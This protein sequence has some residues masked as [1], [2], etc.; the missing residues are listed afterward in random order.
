MN[1]SLIPPLLVAGS[2]I[3]AVFF[4]LGLKPIPQP[5]PKVLHVPLVGQVMSQWCWAAT[6]E[7]VTA[8]YHKLDPGNPLVTQCDLVKRINPSIEIDC[9]DLSENDSMANEPGYPFANVKAYSFSDWL[10][11]GTIPYDTLAA[12]FA[13]G[14]PV[15]FQWSN[16]GL[17]PGKKSD[18][19]LMSGT[20]YPI[21]A[22]FL[23]ADGLPRSDYSD[24]LWVSVNDP[25]PL[26]E[27]SHKVMAYSAFA[28]C[29]PSS[30]Q[31]DKSAYLLTTIFYGNSGAIYKIQ[32]T[33][34]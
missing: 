2:S 3:A 13:A 16:F 23:V 15:I 29:V 1:R 7:M 4:L 24:S 18:V 33:K 34:K 22:H 30:H 9:D 8:Y 26:G 27:G 31:T 19:T 20:D 32:P 5:V 12:E 14:R 21:G 28:G 17:T 10:G 6:T 11:V 25:L